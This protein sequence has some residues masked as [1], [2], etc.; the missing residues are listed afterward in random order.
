MVTLYCNINLASFNFQVCWITLGM[1]HMSEHNIHHFNFQQYVYAL[2]SLQ[3]IQWLYG[4]LHHILS[5]FTICYVKHYLVRVILFN[6]GFYVVIMEYFYFL[7][8]DMQS[9]PCNKHNHRLDIYLYV[10][11]CDN[12]LC[13]SCT[14]NA[15]FCRIL[16]LHITCIFENLWYLCKLAA[17]NLANMHIYIVTVIALDLSYS[18]IC[19]TFSII[20]Y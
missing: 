11:V 13:Q 18:L 14:L 6:V 2:F 3:Y 17:C 5:R 15:Y 9:W 7:K 20:F 12:K 19:L 10:L 8:T 16:A 1:V 4:M